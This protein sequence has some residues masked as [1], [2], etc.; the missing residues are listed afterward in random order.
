VWVDPQTGARTIISDAT[1]GRGPAFF[2]PLEI[3]VEPT[4]TLV[5]ARVINKRCA[6]QRTGKTVMPG[7]RSPGQQRGLGEAEAR[8][9]SS[10]CALQLRKDIALLADHD[11]GRT[12]GRG[13]EIM[14]LLEVEPK[15]E[16]PRMLHAEGT[17][18]AQQQDSTGCPVQPR[19]LSRTVSSSTARRNCCGFR[20]PVP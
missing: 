3:A 9:D 18:R 16:P 2:S 15:G 19:A 8:Q 1:T 20:R 17:S 4:G 11:Q 13:K 7:G 10:P 12:S 5:T 6:S 14:P